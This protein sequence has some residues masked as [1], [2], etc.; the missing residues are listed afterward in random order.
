MAGPVSISTQIDSIIARRKLKAEDM[1][2]RKKQ[3]LE[4]RNTFQDCRQ[5]NSRTQNIKNPTLKKQ[6]QE[7]FSQINAPRAIIQQIDEVMLRMDE[8]I[9]RFERDSLTIATVGLA[10]QGKSTFL[11]AV[12]N[13]GNDIIPAFDA[14]DCTGA[15][16]IIRNDPY[17][18]PGKVRAEISFRSRQEMVDIVS[19]YIRFISPQYLAEH[20]VDYNGIQRINLGEVAGGIEKKEDGTKEEGNADKAK[21]FG[22]LEKIVNDFKGIGDSVSRP[23]SDLCGHEGIVLTDPNEIRKYVAQNN[24]TEINNPEHESYCSYLAVKR[25]VITCHFGED[26]GKLVLVDT[27]GLGDVQLGIE[28]AMLETVDKQSDAAIV[29]TMPNAGV[30]QEDLRLYNML[31]GRFKRRDMSKWLFYLVNENKVLNTN[32]VPTFVNDIRTK[33]FSVAMCMPVDCRNDAPT[34]CNE[35]LPTVLNTLIANMEDI[36]KAYIGEIDAMCADLK[37]NL[38]AV[39]SSWPEAGKIDGGSGFEP[40]AYKLGIDCYE[41]LT[42][43]LNKQVHHLY[44]ERNKPNAVMWNR[45]KRILDNLESILPDVD[46][47]QKV[48]DEKGTLLDHALWMTPLNYV[49]NE[50]TD[51]FIAI[52]DLMEQETKKFKNAIVGELY[53]SLRNLSSEV[54]KAEEEED[55]EPDTEDGGSSEEKPV[56]GE[57]KA[58]P[59]IDQTKW[60]WEVMEPLIRGKQ[61]YSQIYKAF[62]FLNQFEFNVRAQLIQEVRNQLRIINPMT[63][64]YMQPN[65]KFEQENIG[66]SVHFFMASRLA[67]LEDGLRHNLALMNKMPNQAF[68]AAA[69]EFYDRLTFASDFKNGTFVEMN[70]VWGN[71]FAEYSRILWAKKAKQQEEFENVMKEYSQYRSQLNEKLATLAA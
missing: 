23:I 36:D 62:Q 47:L 11:Q 69:E 16:S 14:G 56:E 63:R 49:R 59:E 37:K 44:D 70:V 57:E 46:T 3:L 6:C 38:E 25:A 29:V 31:R 15:V 7:L 34:V 40:E 54:R 4:L 52:D 60:L 10:R 30:H 65:Y 18:E 26:V 21:M 42:R 51:Q 9:A 45:V 35:F 32:A 5:L 13:L 64:E 28:E 27:I 33:N 66:Q 48:L 24:G 71:F 41:R 61:E 2:V 22:Y 8:G 55:D 20:P 1:R 58:K 67:I 17:M 68:Y 53:R 19:G 12:S 43:D 50:I 39:I